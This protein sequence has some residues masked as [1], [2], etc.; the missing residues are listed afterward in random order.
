MLDGINEVLTWECPLWKQGLLGVSAIYISE[1]IVGYIVNIQLGWNV[2]NYP[3]PY[4]FMGQICIQMFPLWGLLTYVGIFMGD[5]IRWLLL[6]ED[7]P[8]Y[9]L[10][11]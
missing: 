8:R 7:K 11:F 9:K 6:G 5:V 4:N 10:W 2:W 1:F 3:S